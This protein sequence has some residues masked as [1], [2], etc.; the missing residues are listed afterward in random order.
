M[1]F[2]NVIAKLPGESYLNGLTTSDLGE[3]VFDKLLEQH[4]SYIEALEK[5]GVAVTLQPASEAFPDSTFV[6]DA[7]VLT[8]S[9]AVVTNPGAKSRNAEKIEIE[10]V[11]KKFYSK[12][13]YIQGPGTLDGGDVL[14]AEDEFYIGISERTNEEGAKQLKEILEGEG[15]GAT[16]IPLREFFHLKTGIAYLGNN[17]MVVAGEFIE[18]P[19]FESYEKIVISKEDEYSANCIR[20]ND[21]VIIPSGFPKTKQKFMDAGYETIELDM[22]EVQKHDGGLSCLSLRF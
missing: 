6:E 21:Y 22:S 17:H 12:F 5:C 20:V 19:A 8:A 10:S 4:K 1:R 18:H 11:L 16:I 13:Y 2:E 7:A 3:P 14:Q 15:Y 9:F